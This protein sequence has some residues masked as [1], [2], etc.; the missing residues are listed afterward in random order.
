VCAETGKCYPLPTVF[1]R[2]NSWSPHEYLDD[3]AISIVAGNGTASRSTKTLTVWRKLHL[4]RD[5]MMSPVNLREGSDLTV[6]SVQDGFVTDGFGTDTLQISRKAMYNDQWKGGIAQFY[7][8]KDEYLGKAMITANTIT[9]NGSVTFD[10]NAPNGTFHV[11]VADDDVE[12]FNDENASGSATAKIIPG[13]PDTTLFNNPNMLHAAAIDM[14]ANT[15]KDSA[16]ATFD[17]HVEPGAVNSSM[18]EKKGLSGGEDYW[19]ATA[20]VCYQGPAEKSFDGVSTALRGLSI[21]YWDS[22]STVAAMGGFDVYVE[23]IRD[24]VAT[25]TPPMV[26]DS[27]EV[28]TQRVTLHE[29]GHVM[30]GRHTDGGLMF[31]SETG[32]G[33]ETGNGTDPLGGA[34]SGLSLRRFMLL[35]AQGPGQPQP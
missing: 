22:G 3:T 15:E 34:F 10:V 27:I 19:V 20:L 35:R 30:G 6:H 11:F 26:G 24:F 16:D 8:S 12:K 1:S 5:Y 32:D 4:E 13:L 29:C 14:V 28:R 23:T 17:L 9:G 25:H 7:N 33:T 18:E 2:I 21:P 31:Y